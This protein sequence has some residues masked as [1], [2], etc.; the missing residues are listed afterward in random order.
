MTR[1][2]C[3]TALHLNHRARVLDEPSPKSEQVASVLYHS[4]QDT[5]N[6]YY[7]AG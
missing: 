2:H 6:S 7:P 1:P 4:D 5:T 3:I